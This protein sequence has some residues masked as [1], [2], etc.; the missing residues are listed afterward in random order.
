MLK[1]FVKNTLFPSSVKYWEQRYA[2]GGNSGAGS[3]GELAFFKANIINAFVTDNKIQTIVEFGCGDGYQLSLY[4]FPKYTGLDISKTAIQLCKYRFGNDTTKDF[5][6][7]NP[8][9]IDESLCAELAISIDVIFHLVED[10]IF[11]LYMKHL[12]IASSQFVI[13]YSS[14][15]NCGQRGHERRRQFT[16]WIR[17][18]APCWELEDIINGKHPISYSNFYIYKRNER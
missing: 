14:D 6:Q 12:F 17:N 15:F 8:K 18:N 7:Y 9:L 4:T 3:Y 16:K 1:T 5:I 11:E 10:D 2:N 13:I